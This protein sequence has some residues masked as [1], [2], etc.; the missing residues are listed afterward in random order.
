MNKMLFYF[1][2][3]L[4]IV[5]IG[6]VFVVFATDANRQNTEFLESFGWEISQNPIETESFTLPDKPNDVYISYNRLQ[7]EAGLDLTPYFGKSGIRYTYLVL[8]YPKKTD[9]EVRANLLIID[10]TPVAGDIMT[11]KSDGFMHSLLFPTD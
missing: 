3:V 11:V 2:T 10:S 6:M 9:C 4:L 8:N 7:K 5:A 1:V